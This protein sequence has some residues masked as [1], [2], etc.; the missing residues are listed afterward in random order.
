MKPARCKPASKLCCREMR[1]SQ[2][3]KARACG[4]FGE[5][6][7]RE[8]EKRKGSRE[9]C[10]RK[11]KGRTEEGRLWAGKKQDAGKRTEGLHEPG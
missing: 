4:Q 7:C 6:G 10:R 5:E 11:E 9:E 3:L 2:A 8:Q 1:Q